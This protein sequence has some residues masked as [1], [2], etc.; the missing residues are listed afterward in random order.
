MLERGRERVSNRD[1]DARGRW[2][3]GV[4]GRDGGRHD[5][6]ANLDP[7]FRDVA[8]VNTNIAIAIALED[9]GDGTFVCDTTAF[10][11]IDGQG[12]GNDRLL[13]SAGVM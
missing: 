2:Q 3:A 8:G 9:Q 5:G 1:G 6:T 7:W 11:P 10:V 12:F 4:R 13:S